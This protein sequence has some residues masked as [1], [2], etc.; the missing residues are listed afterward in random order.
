MEV[1]MDR[2]DLSHA[3]YMLSPL[4]VIIVLLVG[5]TWYFMPVNGQKIVSPSAIEKL[6]P[7][8]KYMV[9]AKVLRTH[10]SLTEVELSNIQ[11]DYKHMSKAAK[12]QI[13][14]A[15]ANNAYK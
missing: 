7:V 11:W 3:A 5:V 13:E 12:H 2:D 14:V 15:N 1:V 4:M 8:E 10:E 9:K 6:N